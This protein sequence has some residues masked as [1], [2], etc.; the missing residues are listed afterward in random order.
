VRLMP[1]NSFGFSAA[2]SSSVRSGRPAGRPATPT[3][4]IPSSP[5]LS[6]PPVNRSPGKEAGAAGAAGMAASGYSHRNDADCAT[7]YVRLPNWPIDL[8]IARE[9][10]GRASRPCRLHRRSATSPGANACGKPLPELG[11]GVS[12]RRDIPRWRLNYQ[13]R[14]TADEGLSDL[15]DLRPGNATG[16]SVRSRND[17]CRARSQWS[18]SLSQ[19][20]V[21]RAIR[22]GLIESVRVSRC[23]LV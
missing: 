13:F 16:L 17:P 23:G 20:G 1:D 9:T 12:S 5:R 7:G 10:A 15:V 2:N 22:G 3:S 4:A 11:L 8:I 14:A 18:A 19:P 21:K 6:A